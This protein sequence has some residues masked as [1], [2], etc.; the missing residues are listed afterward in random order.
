MPS[1]DRLVLDGQLFHLQSPVNSSD[2]TSVPSDCHLT[3]QYWLGLSSY[4][5]SGVPNPRTG[6]FLVLIEARE[7]SFTTQS[8]SEIIRTGITS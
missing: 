3:P 4:L 1:A 6:L 5:L 7:D 2:T 8:P